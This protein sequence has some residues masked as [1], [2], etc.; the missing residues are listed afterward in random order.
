MEAAHQRFRQYI[1]RMFNDAMNRNFRTNCQRIGAVGSIRVTDP[2]GNDNW[3]MVVSA[4][5]GGKNPSR[6]RTT[7]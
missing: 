5:F 4:G 7:C 1:D 6:S 2:E 3:E